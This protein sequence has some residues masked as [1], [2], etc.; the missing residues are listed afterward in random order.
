MHVCLIDRNKCER[1]DNGPRLDLIIDLKHIV[2]KEK[3]NTCKL[4]FTDAYFAENVNLTV[5]KRYC[6]K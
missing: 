3:R 1:W 4:E 2:F 6:T 5:E